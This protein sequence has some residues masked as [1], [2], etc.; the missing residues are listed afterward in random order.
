MNDKIV[1]G[2]DGCSGGWVSFQVNTAS[3]ATEVRILDIATLLQNRP[4]DLALVAVDIPIGLL[5]GP[6]ACD[7][8]ARQLLGPVRGCSVFPAP[9]RGA[10]QAADYRDAC[11]L[12]RQRTGR[13]LSRQAW[14]ICPKVKAVDDA[15]SPG[16]QQWAFEVHPEVSFWAINN[17]RPMAHRKKSREGQ[18]ER[19]TLLAK[20][21]PAIEE[22]V[23][24]RP[25][26]VAVD[27]L[28]DAAVA[29]WSALRICEGTAECVCT[30]E[31]DERGLEVTIRY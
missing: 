23:L 14:C 20:V 4:L 12:N 18:T 28:L 11:E 25:V 30:P 8:A 6:R 22:H 10:L 9:S 17:G 13:R 26:H 16:K 3:Q 19:L 31:L 29:A 7:R 21:F 2:V 27:D 5:D 15:V 24:R 1:A